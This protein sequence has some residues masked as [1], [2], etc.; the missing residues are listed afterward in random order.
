VAVVVHEILRP[1]E[2][3]GGG[4]EQSEQGKCSCELKVLIQR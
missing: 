2:L 1:E 3:D 4:D